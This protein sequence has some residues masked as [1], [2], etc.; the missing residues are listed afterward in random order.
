MFPPKVDFPASTWPMNT[1]LTCSFPFVCAESSSESLTVFILVLAFF[2]SRRVP[3]LPSMEGGCEDPD[4][5]LF[6]GSAV[7]FDLGG[8][9]SS[10]LGRVGDGVVSDL[11][12]FSLVAGLGGCFPS[13]SST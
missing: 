13:H 1:M 3:S 7:G 12:W 11:C 8:H 6:V 4:E 5:R 2:V 9:F 10:F